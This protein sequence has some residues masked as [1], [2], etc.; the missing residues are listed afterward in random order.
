MTSTLEPLSAA[1]VYLLGLEPRRTRRW[2]RLVA[3]ALDLWC[4]TTGGRFELTGEG[5]VVVRLRSDGALELRLP[6]GGAEA[7]AELMGILR[8]QLDTMAP[9]EF[10]LA[11]GL[12]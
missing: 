10:R 8:H 6:V 12:G 9:D 5:Y 7:A 11:W 1:E 4:A 3:G 2:G